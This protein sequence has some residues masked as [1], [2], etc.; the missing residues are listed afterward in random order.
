MGRPAMMAW[1]L[2]ADD[3][4]GRFSAPGID[5]GVSWQDCQEE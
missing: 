2:R 1:H 5:P 4:A 3:M